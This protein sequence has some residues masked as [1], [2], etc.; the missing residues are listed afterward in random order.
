ML[1]RSLSPILAILLLGLTACAPS[2]TP[3][4]PTSAA[5]A[6]TSAP[7][8]APAA[9]PGALKPAGAPS[10][11]AAASP[12]ASPSPAAKP[13]AAPAAPVTPQTVRLGYLSSASDSAIFIAMDKGYFRDQGID[14]QSSQ[15]DSAAL[16]VA[17]LAAGQLDVGGGA[18]GAGLANALA[19]GL[20]MKIVADKGTPSVAGGLSYQAL[21]LRKALWD[22]GEVRGP[23]NLKGRKVA[24]PNLGGISPEALLQRSLQTA[25]LTTK[26]VDL[27]QIAF[28]DML[29]AYASGAIDASIMIEPLLT[30]AVERNL[31][32]K[33]PGSE[34][35]YPDQQVAVML[36]SQ[37]FIESKPDLARRFMVAYVRGL[38]DYNDAFVKKDPARRQEVIGILTKNTA[39]KDPAVYEKVAMPGLDPN[40]RVNKEALKADQAYY[41]QIGKQQAQVNIDELV[42]LSFA[43]YAVQQ[44]GPYR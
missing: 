20:S 30:T 11:A 28:P 38:R 27:V 37:S 22:S 24:L 16:M 23:E 42:D 6:P 21:M 34:T 4:A 40:G 29:A 1:P 17:P 10:P 32:V 44:L 26:D 18:P 3:P 33:W 9:S 8:A 31:A 43:D 41:I 5:A 19:R 13:E 35:V 14:I 36:Y 7:T 2:A 12:V 15:F 39:L 25:S